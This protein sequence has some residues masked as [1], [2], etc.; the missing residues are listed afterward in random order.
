MKILVLE[1][2]RVFGE[3]LNSH[4]SDMDVDVCVVKAMN[5]ALS[6]LLE[7]NYDLITVSSIVEDGG[8]VE[9]VGK[10]RHVLNMPLIPIYLIVSESSEKLI[11]DAY[12]SEVTGVFKKNEFKGLLQTI[13]RTVSLRQKSFTGNALLIEDSRPICLIMSAHLKQMGFVVHQF[14]SAKSA[15]K[16][17]RE[18][19][20]GVIL[21][22]LLLED[23]ESGL[24]ILT[25]VRCDSD[26]VKSQT[27]VLITTG[28]DDPMKRI[29]LF[30]LGADDYMLK[31]VHRDEL[32]VR[33]GK[34]IKT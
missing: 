10:V 23:G 7:T 16:S 31:P 19:D 25:A 28:N 26:R 17:F 6:K 15:L 33:I 3:L 9:F 5:V 8:Y 32:V 21:L 20:Y 12:L 24:K 18:N 29:D 34:I 4:L 30:N 14:S 13:K 22:D 11:D 1:L 2:D 27:P